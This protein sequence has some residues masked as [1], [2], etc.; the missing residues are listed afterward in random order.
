MSVPRTSLG[1]GASIPRIIVG[2]WQ[3]STGHSTSPPDRRATLGTWHAMV[4]RGFDTFDCADIY[5]GVES[6]LGELIRARRP[7]EV[8]V[9][10][11]L[12]PD[13]SA[14]PTLRRRDLE[15]IVDRSL[16]RLG[17]ERL[18]L[19]QFHW[20]SYQV[21]GWLDA[22][23]WLA[24][25]RAAGKIADLGVTN[26]D[27]P[28]LETMLEAKLPVAS[29]QAQY[30]VLDR[31]PGQGMAERCARS[32]VALLCYGTVAGGFLSDRWRGLP[33]P[34]EPL[35]NRSLVKYR[36]IIEECGGWEA[37]Q[38]LLGTLGGVAERRGVDLASVATRWVL[39][40]P[41]V[42]AAIVGVRSAEHLT[43]LTRLA[44]LELDGRDRDEIDAAVAR[45]R[46]PPGDVYELER[47]PTGVHSGI[48]RYDLNR[49]G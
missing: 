7:G 34:R 16:A 10:T 32:D 13:R 28:R 11:K 4:D 14:L 45:L 21:P 15:R 18:D 17:L 12:V 2:G 26:F 6:L 3:L 1:S 37:V 41:G 33:P 25:M 35:E 31:R 24:S 27:L 49:E 5:Q 23:S 20:W 8:R 43:A 30:S 36:L 9:H 38:G 47:D 44:T 22:L 29:I 48:M 42:S 19:V 39:E 40:Q 46:N